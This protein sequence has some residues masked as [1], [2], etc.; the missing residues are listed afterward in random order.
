MLKH[1]S[2][3]YITNVIPTDWSIHM[4]EKETPEHGKKPN[5]KLKPYVVLQYLLKSTD[6]DHVAT[7]FDIIA[8]LEDEC[9]I[10][11][12]R[13]SIYKDIEE[14]NKVAL[15][16]QNGCMIDEATE[17]LENNKDDDSIRLVVYDKSRK[18]F[19]AQKYGRQFDV[20]DMR[21]LAECVY[22]AKFIAEGQANRLVDKVICDFVSVHQ[23]EKIRH[24][25]FLT[26]RV[27]TNNKGVL[28]NLSTINEAMS[29]K[30]D[31]KSHKPEKIKFKYLKCSI[32]DVGQQIERRHGQ[33]YIVSPFQLIINDGNYYLLAYNE[34]RKAIW[35]YRV[36]R[37]KNVELTGEPR[38]GD[39]EFAK[40]DIRTFAQRTISMYSGR[41]E[42][43]TVRFIMPLLD[44]AIDQFGTKDVRYK[45]L[46]DGH[47]TMT[48][49]IDISDQFF[50]WL[51]RFGRR[52]KILSPESVAEQFA[53]YLNKIRAMYEKTADE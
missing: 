51:L 18:G 6:E 50:G 23:A 1:N 34:E 21:L 15:M 35:T 46:D 49:T 47:F 20:D 33:T 9:G 40:I 13:R 11:A 5:Q 27:K 45:K 2:F 25:A 28:R 52:V 37:M 8:F 26:D 4:S 12:E 44:T 17:E 24:D 31:G 3:K 42:Q 41:K 38:E 22:S 7:A 48:A 32:D 29:T 19:Y 10:E 14:I 43:V 30:L 39:E 16:F 53:E 36:D